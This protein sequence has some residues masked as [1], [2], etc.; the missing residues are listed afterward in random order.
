MP[1]LGAGQSMMVDQRQH[2][3]GRQQRD[4]QAHHGPHRQKVHA[5]LTIGV[6]SQPVPNLISEG[7]QK[8]GKRHGKSGHKH[9]HERDQPLLGEI[10]CLRQLVGFA[11]S[12]HP[13]DHAAGACPQRKQ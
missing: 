11:E 9:Q 2:G 1:G 7:E 5:E 10:P 12:F 13:G 3:N 8:A 6:E 4:Q